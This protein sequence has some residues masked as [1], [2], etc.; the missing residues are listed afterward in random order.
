MKK[1][2]IERFV[3]RTPEILEDRHRKVLDVF[4]KYDFE[5]ILDVGCGDGKFTKLIAE[6]CRAKEVHGLEISESGVEMAKKNGIN[7]SKCDELQ[8]YSDFKK[9]MIWML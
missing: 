7:C 1:K 5:R 3:G 2:E 8:S 6:A 4:S 9:V